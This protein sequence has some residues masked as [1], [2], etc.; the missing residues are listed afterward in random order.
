VGITK[1]TMHVYSAVIGILGKAG[2]VENMK[3][4]MEDMSKNGC[5]MD[6]VTYTQLIHAYKMTDDI[7]NAINKGV[8]LLEMGTINHLLI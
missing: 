4:I 7:D 8:Y 3:S 6:I 5:D 2:D 1:L